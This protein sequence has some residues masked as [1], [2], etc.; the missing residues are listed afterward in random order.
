MPPPILPPPLAKPEVKSEPKV[1]QAAAPVPSPA[2][3]K[4]ANAG[5]AP[6]PDKTPEMADDPFVG[7]GSLEAEMARL[8]GRERMN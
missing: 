6:S 7:L 8:L 5:E 1:D 2:T 3:A 4:P